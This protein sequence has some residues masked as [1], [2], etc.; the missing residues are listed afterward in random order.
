[1]RA[2]AAFDD[3]SSENIGSDVVWTS[4][5]PSIAEIGNES[6]KK[7]ILESKQVGRITASAVEPVSGIS[8]TASNGDGV[9]T[10]VD[11][12][13]RLRVTESNLEL[14]TADTLQLEAS[15]RFPNPI[16]GVGEPAKVEVEV[17]DFVEWTSSDPN[18]VRVDASGRLV[19]VGLGEATVSARD[20][21]T[22]ISSRDSQGDATFRVIAALKTLKLSPRRITAKMGS[23][24][25]K[26]FTA[27]GIYTDKA[28]IELTDRVQF[29]SQND[30]VARVS[31]DRDR[32]G[33]VVPVGKGATMASAV[34]PI[35]GVRAVR[36]RRIVVKASKGK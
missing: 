3:G 16:S 20:P 26:G 4:S 9:V 8:T 17:T 13:E 35:T 14:R 5:D 32:H 36:P 21:K 19:A 24:R 6:P 33:L 23:G 12:L 22:G 27:L 1:M 7:A 28:R 31:N 18:V 29:E 11:G 30:E 2:R 25:R 10:I 15:G 34:E